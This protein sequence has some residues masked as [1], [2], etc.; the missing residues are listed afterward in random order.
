MT[1]KIAEHK[2]ILSQRQRLAL[3]LFEDQR[4]VDLLFGGGAGGGKTILVCAWIILQCRNYPG[5]RIGL[6]R[7]ELTRLKQTT[8]VTLLRE[9]HALMGVKP[10]EFFYSDH[11]S[12]VTYINGSIVQ[13]IDLAPLPSDPNFDRFGSLNFTHTVIEEVGEVARRAKDV[14]TSRKN[15]FM[16]AEYNIVGKS[17]A[18]CNPAQSYVKT[19]YYKPYKELGGGEYQKWEYGNVEING[20]MQPAYRAFIRSLATDNPYLPLNY[21]EVLR[22]LPD[23]ERKRLLEGNWDFEDNDA[24][25]FKSTTIDRCL[26]DAVI[27]GEKYIGAD[28]ADTGSDQ[29]IF[30]L[31]EGDTIV[32]QRE[33]NVDKNEAI[34]EQIALELIKY[35]QQ[36]GLDSANAKNIGVD[37]LG[38]GASTR[39]FMRSKGWRINDFIAGA[40][41][42][43]NFKNLRGETIYG[44]G[45]A[46]DQ[47]K[48]KIFSRLKTLD[49]LRE[50]L[51]AHE[52]TTEERTIVVKSK[53]TIKET[54]G[55]SPDHAE[56]AYIAFWCSQG[57]RDPKRD[58]SRIIF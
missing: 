50:Q 39:D 57:K 15:R 5:I 27:S 6:G 11:K 48:L 21:I 26:V 28:I 42:T 13:L 52:Y 24:M 23:A 20:V 38:V 58:T 37:T 31:I 18:T 54:L 32:E 40:A 43:S 12:T 19:E 33:I 35:A 44:M 7:K 36:N 56:S 29:T 2:I 1:A 3:D 25:I 34:G 17:I 45:Q 14:F 49:K 10:G 4:V 9:A 46:L 53:K 16:N 30:T 51:M 47:G 22:K 8:V 41:S 55:R